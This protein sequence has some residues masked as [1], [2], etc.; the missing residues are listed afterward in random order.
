MTTQRATTTLTALLL[1]ASPIVV[2]GCLDDDA[3]D[4]VANAEHATPRSCDELEANV[5]VE[6]RRVAWWDGTLGLTFEGV[7]AAG[8]ES[9]WTYELDEAGD[10]HATL[11]LRASAWA[12]EPGA[13][14]TVVVDA[15]EVLSAHTEALPDPTDGLLVFA[16]GEGELMSMNADWSS[17]ED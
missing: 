17:W 7:D 16:L 4:W 2:T 6:P 12:V 3:P 8:L 14:T 5:V 1:A 9:C 11:E 15:S 13:S 10:G